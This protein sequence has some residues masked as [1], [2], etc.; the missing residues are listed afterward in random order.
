M[1]KPSNKK[2]QN[3]LQNNGQQMI[4]NDKSTDTNMAIESNESS[5]NPQIAN[6]MGQVSDPVITQDAPEDDGTLLLQGQK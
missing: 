4:I 1:S 3:V 2:Q 6:H 5:L